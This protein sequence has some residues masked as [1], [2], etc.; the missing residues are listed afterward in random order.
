MGA[1]AYVNDNCQ[2]FPAIFFRLMFILKLVVHEHVN[3]SASQSDSV[4]IQF[5][6]EAD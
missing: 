2:Y 1:A 5:K 6:H 4:C 3:C